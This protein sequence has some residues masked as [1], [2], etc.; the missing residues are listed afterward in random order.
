MCINAMVTL[1]IGLSSP[2]TLS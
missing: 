2:D 1:F